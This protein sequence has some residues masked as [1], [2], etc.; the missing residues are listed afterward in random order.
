M[1]KCIYVSTLK[2]ESRHDTTGAPL[3]LGDT[4]VL[5]LAYNTKSIQNLVLKYCPMC[6]NA[7]KMYFYHWW[8]HCCSIQNI[9]GAVQLLYI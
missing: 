1:N 7:M 5:F 8:L 2:L 6:A 4:F 9:S 3:P